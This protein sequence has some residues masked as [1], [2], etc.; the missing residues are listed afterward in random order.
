MVYS[1]FIVHNSFFDVV[2][3]SFHLIKLSNNAHYVRIWFIFIL[4]ILF[5][6]NALYS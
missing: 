1:V 5:I 4:N 3:K 6:Q 2:H